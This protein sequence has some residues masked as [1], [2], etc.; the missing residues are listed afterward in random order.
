MTSHRSITIAVSEFLVRDSAYALAGLLGESKHS[1]SV[2]AAAADALGRLGRREIQATVAV[3][4]EDP[5]PEV[6]R[7]ARIAW[8]RL[9]HVR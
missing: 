2:R 6:A 5:D 1:A 7:Q 4:R 8:T 9:S 3:E